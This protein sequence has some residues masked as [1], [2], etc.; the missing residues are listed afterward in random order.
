MNRKSRRF[1]RSVMSGE[2][3]AFSEELYKAYVLKSDLELLLST[4][5]P[6]FTDSMHL[7]YVLMKASHPSERW[8]VVDLAA[9]R[10]SYNFETSNIG[11][12]SRVESSADP[13]KKPNYGQ[14]LMGIL[15]TGND[16]IRTVQ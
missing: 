12:A 10:E 9:L 3:Y 11:L 2:T 15:N 7:F 13:L 16:Y 1:V 6:L 14:P 5:I 4:K 8:L